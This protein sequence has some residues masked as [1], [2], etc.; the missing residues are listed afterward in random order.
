MRRILRNSIICPDGTEL[1]SRYIWDMQCYYDDS[2]RCFCVDG[3]SDYLKRTGVG[4]TENSV[5]DD[6][7]FELQRSTCEWGQNYNKQGKKLKETK[8]VKIKDLDTEHIYN[9]LMNVP[10]ISNF[11]MRLFYDEIKFR[12]E[13]ILNSYGN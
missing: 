2:N 9:I 6:G 5:I 3:G 13:L 8:W 4:Y 12:E 7:T 10:M 1:V 11:Y